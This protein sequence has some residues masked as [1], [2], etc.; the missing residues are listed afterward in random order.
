MAMLELMN[1]AGQLAKSMESADTIQVQFSG[2][3]ITVVTI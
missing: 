1:R 3:V 2:L